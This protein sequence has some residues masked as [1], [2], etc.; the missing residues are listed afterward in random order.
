VEC[1]HGY[2]KLLAFILEKTVYKKKR[3]LYYV[4]LLEIEDKRGDNIM[5]IDE[6]KIISNKIKERGS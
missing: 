6:I 1:L 5:E 2:S 4:N 3:K